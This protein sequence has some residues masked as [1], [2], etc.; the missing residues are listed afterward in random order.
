VFILDAK[1]G[2]L[3]LEKE[4]SDL[5]FAAVESSI[6]TFVSSLSSCNRIYKLEAIT[7]DVFSLLDS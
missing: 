7:W 2:V 3:L 5:K 1:S 4:I 6:N